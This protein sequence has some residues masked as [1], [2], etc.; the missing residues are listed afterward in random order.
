MRTATVERRSVM[1]R[2]DGIAR[3]AA[4]AFTAL[5]LTLA[6]GAQAQKSAAAPAAPATPI[7]DRIKSSGSVRFGYRTDA[8]PFAF[9]NE[10]GTPTGFSVELCGKVAEGLKTELNLT[11]LKIEWVPLTLDERLAAVAQG[12][13]DVL[14][15]AETITLSKRETMTFSIPIFPSGIGALLRVDAPSRLVEILN[16]KP[17]SSPT[18][19]AS[20]GQLVNVQKFSVVNGTTAVPWIAERLKTLNLTAK[21]STVPDYATGFHGVVDGTTNVFFA[22]RATLLY[23]RIWSPDRADLQVLD[24]FF[25]YESLALAMARGDSK[26][27]LSVDRSLSRLYWTPDFRAM[28]VKWFGEPENNVMNF[29]RWNALPE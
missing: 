19:R 12:R 1:S 10:A 9:K 21:V 16:N 8:Q 3:A 13:V 29:Y 7:I 26:F 15:G 20:A 27:L 6:A 14:C 11:A 25:T 2:I 18:W 22:D 23:G 28:Y 5:T 24:R 4:C 17:Q